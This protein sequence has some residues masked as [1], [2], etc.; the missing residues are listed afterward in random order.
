M[1]GG[2]LVHHKGIDLAMEAWTMAAVDAELSVAGLGPMS[3]AVHN[4]TQMGWLD[5]PELLN[6]LSRARALLFPSRWQEPF[7]ILAVE[8]LAQGTPV[9]AMVQG[10]MVD[11]ADAGV[12]TIAPGDVQEMAQAIKTLHTQPTRAAQLGADGWQMVGER[13][14]PGPLKAALW[15]IYTATAQP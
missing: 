7:G 3:T 14:A 2:R 15:A 1:L 11:W 8:A 10:G 9:I 13:Y 4:A 6:A 5:G 12:L